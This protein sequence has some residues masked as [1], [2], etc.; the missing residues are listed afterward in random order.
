MPRIYRKEEVEAIKPI[1]ESV[2]KDFME[3]ENVTG[4]GIG[5]KIVNGEYTD[6]LAIQVY[7]AE[8]KDQKSLKKNE[9]IP[10]TIDNIKTDII[11]RTFVLQHLPVLLDDIA[12]MEDATKYDTL[13]GGISI[14]PCRSVYLKPP[15]VP[16][17]G[18]Y[19]FVGTLGAVVK[20]NATGNKMLLSNFHVMCV[21]DQWKVG[22]KMAQPSLVDGGKCPA[23]VVGEL[24][25]AAL[26]TDVDA[27]ISSHTARP[28]SCEIKEIGNVT[29]TGNAAIGL[30]VRKRGRTTGLTY[31]KVDSLNMT[32]QINYGNGLGVK[33]LK[34]QIHIEPDKT[35]SPIFGNHGDSGSAVV[36]DKNEIVGL[37]FAGG[38][39][40][41]GNPVGDGIANPIQKVLTALNISVCTPQII[42]P[43]CK[44][45]IKDLHICRPISTD[46]KPACWPLYRD[47]SPICKPL[48]KD[49]KPPHCVDVICE[50]PPHP[51]CDIPIIKPR[52]GPITRTAD[53]G[54][55][56]E[57]IAAYL[58]QQIIA[59][60][61]ELA[62]MRTLVQSL[63]TEETTT[64]AAGRQMCMSVRDMV[65]P[66]PPRDITCSSS[67]MTP[68][69]ISQMV[70][71]KP[72][73]MVPC[74]PS[75]MFYPCNPSKMLP[76][77]EIPHWPQCDLP[78]PD[79]PSPDPWWRFTDEEKADYLEQVAME[80][81]AE[82][83]DIRN[84]AQ[85]MRSGEGVTTQGSGSGM[86]MSTRD[87][88]SC[89][90]R[91]LTCVSS[92]MIPCTPSKMICLP[93][94]MMHCKPSNMVPCTHSKMTAD[95]QLPCNDIYCRDVD[96]GNIDPKIPR[97]P[98]DQYKNP[99]E[100]M[101]NMGY[102]DE[103]IATYLEEVAKQSEADLEDTRDMIKE[104]RGQGNSHFRRLTR[105]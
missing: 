97:D 40:A 58:E 36:N 64:Q 78:L 33:T 17:A 28:I 98:I 93:Y 2:E 26:N 3:M 32:V 65:R 39:D 95:W 6:E 66:C 89:P 23:D 1:K 104:L 101:V 74:N 9:I 70:P 13:M 15:E 60:E 37:H 72:S 63:M 8:K 99:I 71:C 105:R 49:I 53:M 25:R 14:G 51:E 20:D 43:I 54:Y 67:S 103:E 11:E 94:R 100:H 44:P 87:M 31:G 38:Q 52:P 34:N 30:A 18:Y 85:N 5:P 55:S 69:T 96:W 86:C 21:D 45:L 4:V 19:V 102:S 79:K 41:Q 80:K 7:V 68:C 76:V 83:E 84:M 50:I 47:I 77:C 16:Q 10:K 35:K 29:G 88:K 82:I 61:E 59:I 75:K 62:E 90:P 56:N 92:S 24:Q 42:K 91:D 81:E 48:I 46:I 73:K 27:A 57:E 12:I 22:D